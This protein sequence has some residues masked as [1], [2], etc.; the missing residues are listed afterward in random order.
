M[1]CIVCGEKLLKDWRCGKK[2]KRKSLKFC[3]KSCSKSFS[4]KNDKKLKVYKNCYICN[5]PI[6][7]GKRSSKA[8]CCECSKKSISINSF[9]KNKKCFTC[10]K[11][12]QNKNKTGFCKTHFYSSDFYRDKISTSTK[13]KTGGYRKNSNFG[14]GS[15]YKSDWY[16]SPFEV[17]IAK[18][19]DGQKIDYIRNTNR[20]YFI[21]EGRKTYYIPDFYISSKDVFLEVKGYWHRPRERYEKCILENNLKWICLEYKEWKKDSSILLKKLGSII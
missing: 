16:D 12:I 15:Y 7:V 4:T 19:L 18:Y 21:W 3:S 13:G 17:E 8:L 5:N 6:L 14:K 11:P 1:K 10:K 9:S 2:S 20:F